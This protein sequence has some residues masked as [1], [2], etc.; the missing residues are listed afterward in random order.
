MASPT[1]VVLIVAVAIMVVVHAYL[2]M[3]NDAGMASVPS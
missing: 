3:Y 2:A 1:L